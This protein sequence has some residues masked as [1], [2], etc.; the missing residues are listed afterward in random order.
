MKKFENNYFKSSIEGNSPLKEHKHESF[1]KETKKE[2]INLLKEIYLKEDLRFGQLIVSIMQ[3]K[4]VF[5]LEDEL[6]LK[7]IKEWIKQ[8][9]RE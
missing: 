9:K 3:T 4:D 8:N 2:I 6:F 1:S 7:R 5:Y